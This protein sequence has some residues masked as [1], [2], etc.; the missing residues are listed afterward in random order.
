VTKVN[1]KELFGTVQQVEKQHLT[2]W[3]LPSKDVQTKS[4][5]YKRH[6]P[7]HLFQID[8]LLHLRRSIRRSFQTFRRSSQSSKGESVSK[9]CGVGVAMVSKQKN[10]TADVTDTQTL[11]LW[12]WTRNGNIFGGL[13]RR[14]SGTQTDGGWA[15]DS[16]KSCVFTLKNPHNIAARRTSTLVSCSLWPCC[17]R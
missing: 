10:F 17:F 5:Q 11:W 8:C 3:R 14:W 12:F 6:H 15:D 1:F 16:Q 7:L 2:N 13:N 9:F 4:S